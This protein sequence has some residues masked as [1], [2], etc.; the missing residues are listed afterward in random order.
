MLL[1]L[2]ARS[3]ALSCSLLLVSPALSQAGPEPP[4]TFQ[5]PTAH[6]VIA[7]HVEAI[8]G[9]AAIDAIQTMR[10]ERVYV[11][12]EEERTY[13]RLVHKK[14]PGMTRNCS[15][16][17]GSCVVVDGTKGW[18]SSVN[19]EDGTVEWSELG[20]ISSQWTNFEV[21]FALEIGVDVLLPDR[22]Q[23]VHDEANVDAASRREYRPLD[24]KAAGRIRVPEVSHDIE[25][26]D[27]GV[28]QRQP[29]GEG[30]VAAVEQVKP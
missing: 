8:G 7:R 6:E 14:R 1:S 20:S 29:P 24:D 12:I 23:V 28:D 22:H 5:E 16:D 17:T 4:A 30:F 3:A 21:R 15:L 26:R 18:S 9:Q 25:R 2:S 10:Y 27:G 13:H 11:H 19:T